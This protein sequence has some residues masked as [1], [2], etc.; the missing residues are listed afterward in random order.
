MPGVVAHQRTASIYNNKPILKRP[1]RIKSK[2]M[3]R[4]LTLGEF[5][6]PFYAPF[7]G[8]MADNAE[9][10]GWW[11]I[12]Q[13]GSLHHQ[14]TTKNWL[15]T[16][17]PIMTNILLGTIARNVGYVFHSKRIFRNVTVLI[18]KCSS[19]FTWKSKICNKQQFPHLPM[20]CPSVSTFLQFHRMSTSIRRQMESQ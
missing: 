4:T 14:T 8:I 12:L 10:Q 20:K 2:R 15:V 16:S 6:W 13:S 1:Q 3:I 7:S 18:R 19:T 17:T 9:Q 11:P 5:Y